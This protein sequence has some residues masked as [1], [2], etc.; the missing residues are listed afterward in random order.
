MTIHTYKPPG[1]LAKALQIL[2]ALTGGLS[3]IVDA[4][5]SSILRTGTFVLHVPEP[6]RGGQFEPSYWTGTTVPNITW[7]PGLISW[8]VIIVWLIWQH[9]ATANLWARGYAGLRTRP[10]W[11]VGWWFIPFAN[12]AMPLLAM[13]ELDR[14]STS[15]GTPR[16]A[17]SV[18]GWWWAAWLASSLLPAIGAISAGMSAFIDQI[19]RFDTTGPAPTTFDFTAAAH[20]IAPWI[21]L[22]GVLQALAATLAIIVVRRIDGAQRAFPE[23]SV[24]S[25]PVPA[26]PDALA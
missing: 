14:R 2:L 7:I 1:Q 8:A 17:G 3:L 10:G 20:A 26:R 22:A 19:Q 21:L 24:A 13:L 11:A 18:L 25:I 6:T 16:R 5:L 23:I 9:Q 4:W 12:L 15:D